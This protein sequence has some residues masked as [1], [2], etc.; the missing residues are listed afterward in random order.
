MVTDGTA[1]G[2]RD[3]LQ[4]VS[5]S[6]GSFY[7]PFGVFGNSVVL[8]V[9]D[10]QLGPVL[11]RTDGTNSGTRYLADVD[12]GTAPSNRS[13]GQ[14]FQLGQHLLFS[15][16]RSGIGHELFSLSATDPN[17]T[18]DSASMEF[19]AAAIIDVLANDADFDG[20]LNSA[21]VTIVTSPVHGTAT[22]NP[23]DG[24]VTYQPNAAF[25]GSD[26]LTYRVSD[27][28]GRT[29]NVATVRLTVAA[30]SRGTPSVPPPSSPP[31][32]SPPKTGGGGGGGSTS[33][34]LLILLLMMRA[35]S[36]MARTGGPSRRQASSLAG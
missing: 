14:F 27:D 24:T 13:S 10:P 18:D 11:W 35:L 29:S 1:A 31:P 21:S 28:E 23:A 34:C 7:G 15:A 6:G 19:G 25:S 36:D 16:L 20:M 2:T 9:L 5:L 12:P 26:E 17:A 30:S 4:D 33:V 3:M 8:T 32:S 22:V